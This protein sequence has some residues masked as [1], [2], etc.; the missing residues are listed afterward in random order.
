MVDVS[1]AHVVAVM[2]RAPSSGGKTRLF[3]S[4]G[5]PP[6]PEL[7]RALLLDTLD[8]IAVSGVIPVIAYTPTTAEQEMRALAPA[9]IGLMSQREG[10][11]GA[12]MRAVFDDLFAR[13]AKAVIVVGSDLPTLA[14]ETIERTIALLREPGKRVIL[15]PAADGGYYLVAARRTPSNLFADIEWGTAD[16]L[17]QSV[18]AAEAGGWEVVLLP[19]AHD[20]DTL[21]ELRE[22]ATRAVGARRTRAW[23]NKTYGS[24]YGDS[25]AKRC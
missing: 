5:R 17:N 7:L 25:V 12:R 21:D 10:D 2:S 19:K 23:F 22:V 3:E 18:A 24:G 8:G 4:I 20:V 16:V 14:P 13:R 9:G 11:L 6:D 1:D 15:G